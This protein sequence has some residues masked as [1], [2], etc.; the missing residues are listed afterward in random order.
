MDPKNEE[1]LLDVET[2][3]TVSPYDSQTP[4]QTKKKTFINFFHCHRITKKC[5]YLYNILCRCK[6]MSSRLT[7]SDLSLLQ[8]S[9][10]HLYASQCS[11]ASLLNILSCTSSE[12]LASDNFL[13]VSRDFWGPDFCHFFTAPTI[14]GVDDPPVPGSP[15]NCKRHIS[16]SRK[17][18]NVP[19]K[20]KISFLKSTQIFKESERGK[21]RRSYSS[22][23]QTSFPLSYLMTYVCQSILMMYQLSCYTYLFLQLYLIWKQKLFSENNFTAHTHATNY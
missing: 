4:N 5:D 11:S 6:N 12:E 13:Q 21:K 19:L 23:L 7:L 3:M 8:F 14:E 20:T 1:I 9:I 18:F 17:C 10:V 2:K 22:V 15:S 16:R